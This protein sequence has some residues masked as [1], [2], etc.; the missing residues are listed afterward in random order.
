LVFIGDSDRVIEREMSDEIVPLFTDV[1][2]IRHSGG[3]FLPTGAK[4]KADLLKFIDE[5]RQ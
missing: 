5:M 4:V 2:L 1:S 3:H